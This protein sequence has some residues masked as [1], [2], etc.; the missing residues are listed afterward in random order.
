M[1]DF[2]IRKLK[3]WKKKFLPQVSFGLLYVILFS[4]F[5]SIN[6]RSLISKAR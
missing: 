4:I 1:H 2:G 6:A 3:K 5:D